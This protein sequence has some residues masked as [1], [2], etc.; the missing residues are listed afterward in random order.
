MS[1]PPLSAIGELV[2]PVSSWT[3]ERGDPNDVF[4]Y[5]DLSAVEQDAKI[6]SGTRELACSD[7]PSRARQLVRGG[8]VLVSTVRPNLNG[9]ARVPPEFDGATASTGFCVL[10]PKADRLDSQYL[11]QWV[12]SPRFV[13]DMV[14]KATGAS[15]P[16]VSD[17]IVCESKLPLPPLPEQRRIAAILDKADELRAKRRA[18]L[19]KLDTLTQSIFLDMFGDPATNP[20]GFPFCPLQGVVKTDTIVTYGIVQ[21]GDEFPGGVPYI[22]SGDIVDGEIVLD[23]LR[24][25]T[26]VIADKFRRSRVETGEIVMSIRATVGTTAL[27]PMSLDGANL[28]QGTARIAPGDTVERLYLLYLLRTPGTQ[29]WIKLQIK[30]VTFHEIT[31]TRLRELPV[32]VAPMNLQRE[33]AQRAE[34]V[35]KLHAS[36]RYSL[37][38]LNGLFA[39]LQQRAFRGEL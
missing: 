21:A 12:K 38:E 25:T 2:E 37:S 19:A 9:V 34:V 14:R 4:T 1:T 6:I 36:Q 18:A 28:T 33:F 32:M 23:G 13:S 22:R 29:H 20:K 17:C 5:I 8:D 3:P 30:G 10:R 7:A 26:P 31:L 39:S 24:H 16:A 15:Y 11:Y 35:A 27:V